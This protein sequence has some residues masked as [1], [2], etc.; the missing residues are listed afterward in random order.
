M[1]NKIIATGTEPFKKMLNGIQK[2]EKVVASSLGPKGHNVII[3]NNGIRPTIT[4]DGHTIAASVDSADPFEAIGI[5]LEKDIISKVNSEAGDGTTTTTIYSSNLFSEMTR[6]KSLEI[7]QNELRKGLNA[8]SE[9][10]VKFFEEHKKPIKSFKDVAMIST[11]GNEEM[12]NL[13]DKAY[14]SI[15]ENGSVIMADSFKRDGSSYVETSTGLKWNGGI[16]SDLFI[17]NTAT[18]KAVLE[19]PYILVYASGV[20][21]LKDLEAVN[22][23]AQ[24]EGKNLVVVAPFFEPKIWSAAASSGICLIM[25]P[26]M[27]HVELHEV[28]ADFAITVGTKVIPDTTSTNSYIKSVKDLGVAKVISASIGE[29]QVTQVDELEEE[30][31]TAYLAYVEKLKKEI[32]ENDELSRD[33]MDAKKDRL[34]RLSGGVATVHIGALTPEEREEKCYLAEDANHS[35]QSAIKYGVLPGGGT[36]MLKAARMLE[37]TIKESNL[38]EEAQM[39]YRAVASALKQPAKYLVESV[40]PNDYQYIV[41]Q[42]VHEKEFENGYNVRKEKITNL[43]KDG[44]VDSAAI[45]IFAVKYSASVIGSFLLSDSVI[46]NANQNMKIDMNDRKAVEAFGGF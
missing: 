4:K 43:E 6:L 15:G 45:E 27:N 46:L 1:N 11:N 16:P 21:D 24:S 7:D 19:D 36:A 22:S 30:K 17:T 29:T 23:L 28:L 10:V 3:Y 41:Q 42:V 20:K 2:V 13:F 44:V 37:D 39:G 8:A 14:S 31:A 34:A 5:M 35:I 25:S 38:S 9:K 12:S 18:D 26:Q 40:K 33:V 32:D